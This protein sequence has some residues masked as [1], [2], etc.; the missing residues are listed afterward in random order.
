MHADE[1]WQA[2]EGVLS[3]YM[4]TV[5]KYVQTWKL[6]FKTEKNGVSSLPSQQQGS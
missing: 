3:K 1:D 6:N 4:A 5:D 2:M